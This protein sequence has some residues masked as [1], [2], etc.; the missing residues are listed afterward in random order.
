MD[1]M[2]TQKPNREEV[3]AFLKSKA[4]KYTK[5]VA[6]MRLYKDGLTLTTTD[7]FYYDLCTGPNDAWQE[8]Y[9]LYLEDY[10]PSPK[11]HALLIRVNKD[12]Y[13][14]FSLYSLLQEARHAI[15][16]YGLI[17]KKSSRHY[18]TLQG[19]ALESALG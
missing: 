7:G 18:P 8:S 4:R 2:Q 1:N 5:V 15:M 16:I 3:L 10:P 11:T 14:M 17:I 12:P 9:L 6:R 13:V 19:Y